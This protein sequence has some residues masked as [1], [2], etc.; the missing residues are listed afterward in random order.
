MKPPL[1]LSLY[2][3]TDSRLTGERDLA[4]IVRQAVLGGVGIVQLRDPDASTR[5]LID[6]ANVLKKLLDHSDIPLIINDRVDVAMA[7][8]AAG[9]H[10]GATD[11]P[12]IQ[13]RSLLGPDALVG[14]SIGSTD[15]LSA[16]RSS[17][18][19]VDYVGIG[20]VY[21]TGTKPDAGAAIG[22]GGLSDLAGQIDRPCVAIGGI[23]AKTAR[24]CIDAGADGVAVV[25]AIV[26]AD[27][28]R[29]AAADLKANISSW[30]SS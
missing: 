12:A 21:A 29:Q 5:A 23:D 27:D 28:P 14:L 20:P 17:I 16:Q 15:E 2:L 10:L 24:S 8:G 9:V 13:A 26:A 4:D 6:M 19:S 1:D 7:T 18:S 22:I 11:M 3:V 30:R 25:S